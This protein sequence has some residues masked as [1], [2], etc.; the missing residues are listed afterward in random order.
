[1][2]AVISF[3]LMLCGSVML[4]DLVGVSCFLIFLFL[5]F[6][7]FSN[8]HV[9]SGVQVEHLLL[10]SFV[11]LRPC[12]AFILTPCCLLFFV[13]CEGAGE[14]LHLFWRHGVFCFFAGAGEGLKQDRGCLCLVTMVLQQFRF[15]G[16]R[17]NA[18]GVIMREV[19]CG[20]LNQ[21]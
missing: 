14:V 16:L 17:F 15:H 11:T 7:V 21:R 8:V 12:V 4:C 19:L 2:H 9:F 18:R 20:F 3:C 5:C 1:M 10:M 13:F 6:Y